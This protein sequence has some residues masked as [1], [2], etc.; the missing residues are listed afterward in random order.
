MSSVFTPLSLTELLATMKARS[1]WLWHGYLAPGSV[2]LLTSVWKA[3]KTTLLA[4][5]LDRLR[6][7]GVL[8]GSAVAPGKA[9]IVSEEDAT[10]WERRS[11]RLNFGDHVGWLC[12]PFRAK[13]TP[14]EWR[15]LIAAV[16]EQ[17]REHGTDLFVI[18]P[19]ASFLP[20][21]DENTASSMLEALLP[22]QSLTAL[23][24]AVLLLHHPRK[25]SSAAGQTARGSGALSGHVDVIVE[26]Q[27]VDDAPDDRRRRLRG[28]SR[29]EETPRDRVIELNP[30]GTDYTALGDFEDD[31]FVRGWP[32]LRAVFA[33]ARN[34]LTRREI[35]SAWPQDHER[36][37]D[38][39]LWRWL[40]RAVA[41]GLVSR[42]GQGTRA[43]PFQYWL[44]EQEAIWR[45]DPIW[46]QEE[47]LRETRA[48]IEKMM[49]AVRSVPR[50]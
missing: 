49:G 13:P 3:G 43:E 24:M 10:L 14:S 22:L 26:M 15:A 32:V 46:V 7:G 45:N 2:T 35:S 42:T 47:A 37:G 27:A 21:R 5:L 38:V 48:L 1:H 4:L 19:L 41:R 8:G 39:T 50:D 40:E 25:Q 6:A 16:A 44:P 36:P 33:K 12:R 9:I 18:D 30:E 28:F 23:G 29:F 20:G 34:K 31:L 17:R 11:Q